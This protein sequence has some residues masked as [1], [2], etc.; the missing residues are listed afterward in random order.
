MGTSMPSDAPDSYVLKLSGTGIAIDMPV[1]KTKARKILNIALSDSDEADGD[2]DTVARPTSTKGVT[3]SLREHLDQR[4]AS[5]KS[6]QIVAI[7]SYMTEV[8]GFA[9][10]GRDEIK[11]RFAVAREPLPA[12]FPRDFSTA[13]R[14]GWLAPV[15][16]NL[17]RYYVTQSGVQALESNFKA[18]VRRPPSAKKRPAKGDV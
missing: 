1:D 16:G 11:A 3:L 6:E 7:A 13:V 18:P 15:H 8:E 4:G 17:E 2:D 5:L 10:V 14:S 12:N 9:D